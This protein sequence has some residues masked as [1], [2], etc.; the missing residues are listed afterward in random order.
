MVTRGTCQTSAIQRHGGHG[1][2]SQATLRPPAP[3]APHTAG[4][5][6]AMD[7]DGSTDNS[8]LNDREIIPVKLMTAPGPTFTRL[9]RR[10]R[11]AEEVFFTSG[12][13]CETA[14][15]P[16][17]PGHR[18]SGQRPSHPSLTSRLSSHGK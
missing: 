4:P 2:A 16:G 9:Y 12:Q 15:R 7:T 6:S 1:C 8:F 17:C 13:L 18:T 3:Q 11:T 10:K 5:S 14:S